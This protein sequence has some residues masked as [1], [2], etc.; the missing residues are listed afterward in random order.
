MSSATSA[1]N[2]RVALLIGRVVLAGI[3]LFAAYAKLRPQIPDTPWSAAAI[4]T[5]LSFFAMEVNSFQ[6][7][8]DSQVSFVAHTLPFAEL[9]LG[10]W[11]LSGWQLPFSGAAASA[12][13]AGLFGVM[14]RTYVRGLEINCG[15]FGPGERLGIGSLLRD[16]SM[17]AFA[18]AVTAVAFVSRPESG[19]TAG[20]ETESRETA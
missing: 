7:L 10:L 5:S 20:A 14:V 2:R 3:F 4:K 1:K 9:M 11:L 15:C 12:L 13:L 8:S 19:S 17:L 18:L 16:A 6:L